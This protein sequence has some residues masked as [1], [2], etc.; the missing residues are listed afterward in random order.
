MPGIL[1]K[2]EDY[3][4]SDTTVVQPGLK[5]EMIFTKVVQNFIGYS[6]HISYYY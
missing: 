4:E 3:Y 1:D 2:A 5:T 6:M